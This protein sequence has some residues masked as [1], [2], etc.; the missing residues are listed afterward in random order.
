[1]KDY[2]ISEIKYGE[3]DGGMACGP[4]GGFPIAEARFTANEGESFYVSFVDVGD[5]LQF[6]KT[7]AST[8]NKQIEYQDYDGHEQF[9]ED[10][11][12][13]TLGITGLSDI[14][15][16]DEDDEM[17]SICR[18]MLYIL[19]AEGKCGFEGKRLSEIEIPVS[20]R[21]KDWLEEEFDE[22]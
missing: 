16:F 21:E 10:L 8:I 13:H 18:C 15:D 4:V 9:W 14:Y 5:V 19:E 7:D 22:E 17:K 2:M 20:E 6:F 3:T 12:A 1:M 11:N